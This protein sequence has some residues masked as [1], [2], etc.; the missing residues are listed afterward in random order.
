MDIRHVPFELAR[1]ALAGRVQVLVPP[2]EVQHSRV[3]AD[4][5]NMYIALV[6]RRGYQH[7]VEDLSR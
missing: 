2:E 1:P 5:A 6:W 3:K 7:E 4:K